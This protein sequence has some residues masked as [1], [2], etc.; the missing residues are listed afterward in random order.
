MNENVPG[1]DRYCRST[2]Y[3]H[4]AAPQYAWMNDIVCVA[5]MRGFGGGEVLYDLFEIL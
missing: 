1:S 3:F 5:T 4:T 2:P